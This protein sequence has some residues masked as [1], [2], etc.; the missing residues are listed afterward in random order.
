MGLITLHT[1]TVPHTE[2]E[3]KTR[4]RCLEFVV[5]GGC[6]YGWICRFNLLT[7][8]ITA[9]PKK[10]SMATVFWV[11]AKVNSKKTSSQNVVARQPTY[12]EGDDN[13]KHKFPNP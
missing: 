13:D 4:T 10:K 1:N 11:V 7:K 5:T 9:R 12:P 2:K 3:G 8:R 6:R